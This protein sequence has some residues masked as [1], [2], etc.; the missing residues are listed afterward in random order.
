[1]KPNWRWTFVKSSF[2]NNLLQ[3]PLLEE[4]WELARVLHFSLGLGSRVVLSKNLLF[5]F[6]SLALQ[7]VFPWNFDS[8][9]FKEACLIFDH[10]SSCFIRP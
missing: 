8:G 5:L 10:P 9:I 7:R 3:L 2:Q 6:R 4:A 1:M